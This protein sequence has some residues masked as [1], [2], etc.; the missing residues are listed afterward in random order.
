MSTSDLIK[1]ILTYVKNSSGI[2]EGDV[3]QI[4]RDVKKIR[5]SVDVNNWLRSIKNIMGYRKYNILK[6]NFEKSIAIDVG[7]TGNNPDL[8]DRRFYL[9]HS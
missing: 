2:L 9:I 7:F 5:T 6:L 3:I 4:Q 8:E 1:F